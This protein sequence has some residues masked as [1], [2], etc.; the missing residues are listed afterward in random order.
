M[1]QTEEAVVMAGIPQEVLDMEEMEG[2]ALQ[3]M[4]D[5]EVMVGMAA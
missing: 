2:A 5:K 3:D 4:E 1:L